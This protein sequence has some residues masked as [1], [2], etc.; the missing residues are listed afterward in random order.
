MTLHGSKGLEF[1]AVIIPGVSEGSIPLKREGYET[2]M[3]EERRLLYVGMTRAR[4]ELILVSSGTESEFT[5][6]IKGG[7]L[8]REKAAAGRSISDGEQMSF[9]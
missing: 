5:E 7:C 4:E 1:P 9:L 8:I 6:G 2:D 3:E